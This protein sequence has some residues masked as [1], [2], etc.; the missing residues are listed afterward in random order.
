M[1]AASPQPVA[2]L[3]AVAP[4][5]VAPAA[6]SRPRGRKPAPADAPASP[7]VKSMKMLQSDWQEI[8]RLLP[9]ISPGT[10]M[11]TN[12]L[13]YLHAAHRHYETHLRK[14]GK[15]VPGN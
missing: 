7:A 2:N 8:R 3:V 13:T 10:D 14:T 1:A 11:P 12:I 9:D 4:V 6:A 15:L 5:A